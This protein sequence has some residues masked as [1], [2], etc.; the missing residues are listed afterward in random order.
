LI[1]QIKAHGPASWKS[2]LPLTAL[3]NIADALAEVSL[4]DK[5][6]AVLE[7]AEYALLELDSISELQDECELDYLIDAFRALHLG[8]CYKLKPDPEQFGRHL[9]KLANKSEWG[10]FDGPPAGY[11]DVLGSTGLSSYALNLRA[12]NCQ[13]M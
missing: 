10:L 6:N 3:D 1:K 11:A 8:A 4:Q 9:A 12:S 13:K 5:Q 2:E 7:I